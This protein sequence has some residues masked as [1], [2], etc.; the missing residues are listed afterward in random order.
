MVAAR[1]LAWLSFLLALARGV[2]EPAKA[3]DR[4]PRATSTVKH[5]LKDIRV[6]MCRAVVRE[7]HVEIHKHKLRKDGEDDIYET[8]PAICLAIV[9]NYTLSATP[10]PHVS[11]T[12]TKRAKS[13]DEEDD[14]DYSEFAHLMTLKQTCEMFTDDLQQELSELMYRAAMERDAEEIVAAFCDKEGAT[15]AQP[16]APPPP[17]KKKGG[18]DPAKAAKAREMKEQAAKA[19]E[20]DDTLQ[21]WLQKVD[22][23]GSISNLMEMERENPEAMLDAADLAEVQRGAADIRCAVCRAASKVA[24]HRSSKS[25]RPLLLPPTTADALSLVAAAYYR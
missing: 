22:T 1:A 3:L 14:P 21:N 15:G 18:V 13:L 7:M 4:Q 2:L 10:P 19:K 11:Y 24:D 12:L 23:D 25:W 16:P 5:A 17:R 8:V 20:K 6:Q 9:Q